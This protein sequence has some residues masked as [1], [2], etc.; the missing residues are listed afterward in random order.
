M[1]KIIFFL[2]L[3]SISMI[4]LNAQV[5]CH[6]GDQTP[7]HRDPYEQR[8]DSSEFLGQTSV[9]PNEIIGPQG[10][11]SL[12]WVSINDLLN[13][14][15][16]FENDPDFATANAQRVDVRF[17]FDKKNLMKDF[18]LGTY[19]FANM[20]WNIENAASTY[21]NRLDLVDTMQIYVGAPRMVA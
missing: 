6:Q 9:D 8:A 14:T 10:Y 21:Q 1:K 13:Y 18:V 16:Y 17:D 15:I 4:T 11:D 5:R 20:S 2:F 19:G 3:Q 12:Q 7:P